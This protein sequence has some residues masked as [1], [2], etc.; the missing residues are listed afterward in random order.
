MCD[1]KVV[2]ENG[3]VQLIN[4]QRLI[5]VEIKNNLYEISFQVLRNECLDIQVEDEKI[6]PETS[7]WRRIFLPGKKSDQNP[8]RGRAK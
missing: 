5:G 7:L 3:K 2:F 1:M 6:A 4:G 8:Q